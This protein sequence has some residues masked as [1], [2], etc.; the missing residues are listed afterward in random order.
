VADQIP[1]STVRG[2]DPQTLTL[3]VNDYSATIDLTTGQITS[4]SGTPQG[5]DIVINGVARVAEANVNL[6][7]DKPLLRGWSMSVRTCCSIAIPICKS[8]AGKPSCSG[9]L[10]VEKDWGALNILAAIV[11]ADANANPIDS[12]S[13]GFILTFAPK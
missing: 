13:L 7:A 8:E 4:A 3:E 10:N 5:D 1:V 2:G 9:T 12:K 11:K 6:S